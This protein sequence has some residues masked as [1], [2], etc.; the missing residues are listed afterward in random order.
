MSTP[1]QPG[2]RVRYKTTKTGPSYNENIAG[3]EGEIITSADDGYVIKPDDKFLGRTMW[4]CSYNLELCEMKYDPNQQGETE[5]D[6]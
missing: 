2:D 3:T 6:I 4:C 1:F 5:E